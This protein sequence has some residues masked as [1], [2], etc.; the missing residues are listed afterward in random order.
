MD[1]LNNI[2]IKFASFFLQNT[3]ERKIAPPVMNNIKKEKNSR[4]KRIF[5]IMLI[6]S[7]R[8]HM[9]QENL[10]FIDHAF[11]NLNT[12][13]TIFVDVPQRGF[14]TN[15]R[16]HVRNVSLKNENMEVFIS[17]K[18]IG[19]RSLWLSILSMKPPFLVLEDDVF[20][21][22][23]VHKWY[24]Y[25]VATMN[26][27]KKIFGCS[28]QSQPTVAVIGSKYKLNFRN[29]YTYPLVGSHGFMISPHY[30]SNF[31]DHL[32]TRKK[33]SLYIPN[34]IT[35]AWYKGFEKRKLTNE[36][37]WTQEAVAYTYHNNLTIL[38]PPTNFPYAIHCSAGHAS[39]TIVKKCTKFFKNKYNLIGKKISH[40]NWNGKCFS[41]C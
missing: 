13:V 27:N 31:I 40:V 39:D 23:N 21:S 15:I 20:V 12:R 7:N 34:L 26:S 25:C 19:T 11:K 8:F 2:Y 28:F 5:K 24:N 3:S 10:K 37:M 4:S 9:L 30:S 36:R 18:H 33:S 22:E 6:T 16:N 14:N 29:Q 17:E 38:Y 32:Q 35:T 1:I 41:N